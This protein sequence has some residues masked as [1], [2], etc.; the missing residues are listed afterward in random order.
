MLRD[1][2][3]HL[4]SFIEAFLKKEE[5]WLIV[6]LL[7]LSGVFFLAVPLAS[8]T[9]I[10]FFE[11]FSRAWRATWPFIIFIVLLSLFESLWLFWRQSIF[12]SKLEFVFLEMRIPREINTTPQAMEQILRAI[13]A[14][15][16][17][18][19]NFIEK[20]WDGVVTVWY[21][22][23]MVS[24]GGEI[25]FYI[26]V[27]KKQ[28][29]IIEAAFFSYYRDV[30]LIE[31]PDYVEKLPQ[32]I[33]DMYEK[34]LDMWGTELVLGK[35]EAYPIKTYPFFRKEPVD[36][37][38]EAYLDPIATFLEILAKARAGEVIGIQILIAPAAS[39]W[40]K[41]WESLLEDLRKP[42]VVSLG[43]GDS[44]ANAPKE[45]PIARTPGQV[46]VLEAVENNLSK[47]AFDTMIR[48]IY[49]SPREVFYD[50]LAS[51]G[52]VGAFNQ[53]SMLNLNSFTQNAGMSARASAWTWP[54]VFVNRRGL[55]RKQRMLFNYLNR[56]IP[57]E[58]WM[59][60]F[61]T[62]Y[63]LNFNFATR[64]VVLNIESIATIFHPP[65][66]FVLTAPHV[67]RVESRKMAPPAGLAIFG[68]EKEIEHYFQEEDKN[69]EEQ[70]NQ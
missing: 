17:A 37:E 10:G 55:Y 60:R 24:F 34:D 51:K 46:S 12:K 32:N 39:D 30:E 20:Y 31:V 21:G 18:P 22:L 5:V 2:I 3:D 57:P 6:L 14:L 27:P 38:K 26:R 66:A 4:V 41:R 11:I 69:K 7:T 35:E 61:V 65:T 29:N 54:H 44:E 36:N 70:K 52:L 64:R 47:P 45:V 15:R 50:S 13:Y 53:Y 42:A 33:I 48:I 16:N 56:E 28:R 59:G 8:L 67:K 1:I 58:T 19:G 40:V 68:E 62:S 23:E 43:S 9:N 63:P 49:M 25:H